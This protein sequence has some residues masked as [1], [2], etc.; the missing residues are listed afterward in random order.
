VFF[1]ASCNEQVF[2]LNSEK[3]LVQPADSFFR[4]QDKR[5]TANS[6]TLLFRN[7]KRMTSQSRRLEGKA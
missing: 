7:P 5:K 1:N 3:K 4:F 2:L 6:D